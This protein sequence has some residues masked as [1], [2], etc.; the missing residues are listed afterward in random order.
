MKK[1]KKISVILLAMIMALAMAAPVSAA[2]FPIDIGT[3]DDGDFIQNRGGTEIGGR[4]VDR[5]MYVGRNADL[6]FYGELTVHGNL[7][8]LGTFRNHGTVNVDGNIFCLNYYQGNY[9]VKR[10]TQNDGNGDIQYFDHGNFYNY[11]N[12]SSTP[13]VDVNYAF[14]QVPTVWYC[15]HSSATEATCTKARVCNDCGKVLGKALGHRWKSATCTSPKKCT[16]CGVTSGKALGH[17][18]SA[19]K[20][21]NKATV[22][23]KAVQTRTCTRCKKKTQTRTV[24]KKLK[25]VLKFSRSNVKIQNCGM[26]NIKV[27][28]AN[29]DSV[30]AVV[31]QNKKLV[32]A[33][34]GYQRNKISLYTNTRTGKTKVLVKLASGKKA[35]ITVTVSSKY[36]GNNNVSV[37]DLFTD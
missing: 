13:Y 22:F 21:T 7:Y 11:G 15:N 2:M 17:K 29:G 37:G 3:T 16:R 34:F 6:T 27:T 31:P 35:Y 4:T 12:I 19:W 26:Y 1:W 14:I 36:R 20:T 28:M 18:W 25:P 5:D 10:A 32:K 9:L 24:G 30:K 8:I 33:R 23:K